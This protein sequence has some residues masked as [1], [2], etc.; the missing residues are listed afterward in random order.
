MKVSCFTFIR[1][2]EILGYP[3]VESILSALPVCDE[4]VVAVGNGDD[5]TRKKISSIGNKKIRIVDTIWNEGQK[6]GGFVYAQQKMI[7]LYNCTGDW[8]FYLE[9]DEVLHENDHE[10]IMQ[11]MKANLGDDRVETL[12]F[13]YKHFYGDPQ[14]YIDSPAWCRSGVRIVKNSLRT[15]ATDGLHFTIMVDHKNGRWPRGK[16]VDATIYHYGYARSVKKLQEKLGKVSR[17]WGNTPDFHAYGNIDPM[18]LH[19]FEGTHPSV[20][21]SW[22]KN[23]AS[24][25]FALN[26]DYKITSREKR[27]RFEMR[28]EKIFNIDFNKKHYKVVR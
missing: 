7:A 8:A 6:T 27:H 2:G 12:A 11:A 4:F 19:P 28:L 20:M 17:Y 1:N 14:T 24:K 21:K 23:D 5:N 15:I 13:N 9:G 16:K 25:E 10:A 3:F 22:L 26:P 18:V